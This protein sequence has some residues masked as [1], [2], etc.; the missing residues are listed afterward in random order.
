MA[1]NT[2]LSGIDA[3]RETL[4]LSIE[5]VARALCTNPSTLYRW[6]EE[7]T[8]PNETSLER[9]RRLEELTEEIQQALEPDQ[10][11]FWLDSP[12]PVFGGRSPR[13]MI[14]EGRSE[15]VLGALLS[16][17]H[18]LRTLAEAERGGSG[19]AE[20]IARED[21]PLSARAA[22]ALLDQRIEGL[23]QSMRTPESRAAASRAFETPPRVRIAGPATEDDTTRSA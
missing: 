5:E 13:M 15:T 14:R 17:R 12:A 11:D 6:R 18:L 21:M 8:T 20:L 9:L 16:H 1:A 2:H 10:I 7:G 3:A 22:L 4:G 23:V 19:F